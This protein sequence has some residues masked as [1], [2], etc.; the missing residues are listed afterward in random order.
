MIATIIKSPGYKDDSYY[1]IIPGHE[2][3]GVMIEKLDLNYVSE[4]MN[5][6]RDKD[7]DNANF[8]RFKERPSLRNIEYKM[9]LRGSIYTHACEQKNGMVYDDLIAEVKKEKNRSRRCVV[10][11]ADKLVNYTNPFID[12][13]CLNIIHYSNNIVKLFF[14]ASDVKNELLTDLLTIKK[15]FIDP[16]YDTNPEIHVIASTAQ[17][18]DCFYKIM[19]SLKTE[20]RLVSNKIRYIK[21]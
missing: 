20:K 18:H 8:I 3:F 16:V 12:T 15:Y 10:N 6:F 19:N 14:R 17:N 7:I 11:M 2:D 21:L 9:D 13:S 5:A 1:F 4:K